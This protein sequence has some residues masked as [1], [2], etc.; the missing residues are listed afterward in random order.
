[1]GE[2]ASKDLFRPLEPHETA[3]VVVP[4]SPAADRNLVVLPRAPAD[5]EPAELAAASLYGRIPDGFWLYRD[6]SGH[7]GSAAARW[8]RSD[9]AKD[10]RPVSWVRR[11]DGSEEWAFLQQP[12]L[13][14]LYNLDRLSAAPA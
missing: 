8:D 9:G 10:I 5:A 6:A 13:R 2:L 1:M 3:K 12:A 14:A 11:P 4:F 7:V